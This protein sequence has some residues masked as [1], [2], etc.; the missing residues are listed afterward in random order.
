MS[1][2]RCENECVPELVFCV[3]HAE[4]EAMAL[5]IHQYKK[6]IEQLQEELQARDKKPV[7]RRS[8]RRRT[9]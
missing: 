9:T 7:G 5:V 3:V 2:G 1:M 4:K 8:P 6:K